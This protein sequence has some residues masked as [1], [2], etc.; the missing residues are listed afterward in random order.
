[1]ILSSVD[2]PEA[3][4]ADDAEALARREVEVHVV[5]ERAA[6]EFHPHV[7][8]LDHAIRQLRRG[9]DDEIDIELRFGRILPGHLEIALDPIHRF[10]SPR[11]RRFPHPFELAFQEFLALVLLHLLDRLAFGA[12]AGNRCNCRR[13]CKIVRATARRC[14]WRCGRENSGR[15]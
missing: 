10:R 1:M 15:A 6:A 5:E 8:Q 4:A 3:V 7:A 9:R 11:A 2:L 14:A 13:S 12:R